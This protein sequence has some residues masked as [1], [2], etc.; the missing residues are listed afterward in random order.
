MQKVLADWMKAHLLPKITEMR[1]RK[2]TLPL[3]DFKP[4]VGD[5]RRAIQNLQQLK[6]LLESE[7]FNIYWDA[8]IEKERD[9]PL[10]AQGQPLRFIEINIMFN[11]TINELENELFD[12][13]WETGKRTV[14]RELGRV[15]RAQATY[16]ALFSAEINKELEDLSNH[17]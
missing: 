10:L 2:R 14:Y 15:H 17:E 12:Y 9:Y 8:Y 1:A 13:T 4:L 11:S 7:H 3:R 6:R 5:A 16:N